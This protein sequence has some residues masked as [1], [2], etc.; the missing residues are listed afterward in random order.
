MIVHSGIMYESRI[1]I[2][3]DDPSCSDSKMFGIGL[4]EMV[5]K[6]ETNYAIRENGDSLF[7]QGSGNVWYNKQKVGYRRI[8]KSGD[9]VS[10]EV[11]LRGHSREF[12]DHERHQVSFGINGHWRRSY[13]ELRNYTIKGYR[14]CVRIM[15]PGINAEIL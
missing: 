11:D 5:D 2:T 6:N 8:I 7:L 14:L 12:R 15:E 13:V 4:I 1:K 9:I 10:V 3:F